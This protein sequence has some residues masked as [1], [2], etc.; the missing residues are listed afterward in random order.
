[1]MRIRWDLTV[2]IE[3]FIVSI[4]ELVNPDR[5][6]TII[7]IAIAIAIAI[8][9]YCRM[10]LVRFLLGTVLF[11]FPIE[12]KTRTHKYFAEGFFQNK[13][14]FLSAKFTAKAR[15]EATKL[16]L[17]NRGG[18]KEKSDSTMESKIQT[19]KSLFGD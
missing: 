6:I 14:S 9:T 7:T 15:T 10:L 1:M 11:V 13:D 2:T 17:V 19:V 4:A 18:Q 16:L 5:I 12:T 3:I 8:T